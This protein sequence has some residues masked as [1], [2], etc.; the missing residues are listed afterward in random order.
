MGVTCQLLLTKANEGVSYYKAGQS[1]TGTLKYV[2]DKPTEF[3]SATLSL[4]GSG[5]CQWQTQLANSILIHVGNED[6]VVQHMDLL[7]AK[8]GEVVTIQ[9]GSYEHP[10]NFKLPEEIPSSHKDDVGNITYKVELR[11][12]KSGL[13]KN[14]NKFNTIITVYGDVKPNIPQP[15]MAGLNKEYKFLCRKNFLNLKAQIRKK[16]QRS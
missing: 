5:F 15:L 10:F 14:S 11:F 3:T 8:Q 4:I 2:F 1:V 12:I 16:K 6:Y 9:P 7:Q 13:V